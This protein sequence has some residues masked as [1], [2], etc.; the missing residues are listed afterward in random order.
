MQALLFLSTFPFAYITNQNTSKFHNKRNS[1]PW[2]AITKPSFKFKFLLSKRFLKRIIL[3]KKLS[4]PLQ[5]T[6]AHMYETRLF[7]RGCCLTR[8]QRFNDITEIMMSSLLRLTLLMIFCQL[9]PSK[10]GE[11]KLSYNKGGRS[12][13]LMRSGPLFQGVNVSF[14]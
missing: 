14:T 2:R 6:E 8:F 13:N 4:A 5:I 9:L 7:Y 12:K 11:K 1:Q 3:R 10:R